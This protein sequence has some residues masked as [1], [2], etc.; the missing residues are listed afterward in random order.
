[1]DKSRHRKRNA[2]E[3]PFFVHAS[4]DNHFGQGGVRH[5]EIS[6][7]Y[8]QELFRES[9][10]DALSS[11]GCYGTTG[12]RINLDFRAGGQP[13]GGRLLLEARAEVSF[14]CTVHG[15]G[16]IE[17]FEILTCPFFEPAVTAEFGEM[18]FGPDDSDAQAACGGRRTERL[19]RE[20]LARSSPIWLRSRRR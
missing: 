12:E 10:L 8:A 13:M 11:G 15:I 19:V 5:K 20:V 17:T 3:R 16:K 7:V 18:R 9:V 6:G 2:H 14:S 1:M 4:S